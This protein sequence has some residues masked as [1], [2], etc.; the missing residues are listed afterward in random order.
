MVETQQYEESRA[1]LASKCEFVCVCACLCAHLEATHRASLSAVT[2]TN[3]KE[4]QIS[5]WIWAHYKAAASMSEGALSRH[6][7]RIAVSPLDHL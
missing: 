6:P 1:F 7:V 4:M 2:F 5:S 3:S